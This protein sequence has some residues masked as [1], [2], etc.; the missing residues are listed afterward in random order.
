MRIATVMKDRCHP[1]RCNQ[2]CIVYCP[3]VRAG[4]ET[5]VIGPLGKAVISEE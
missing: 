4:D 5:V 1:K 3:R 2:E